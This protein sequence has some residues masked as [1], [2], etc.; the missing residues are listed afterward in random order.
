MKMAVSQVLRES[1]AL[2]SRPIP[3]LIFPASIFQTVGFI[4]FLR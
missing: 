1:R 4:L 2:L 3:D